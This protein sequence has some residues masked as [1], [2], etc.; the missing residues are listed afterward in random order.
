MQ[1]PENDIIAI[2]THKEITRLYKIFLEIV[3]DI[4]NENQI[5]TD[6]ISKV[7]DPELVNH[8][9]YFTQE[10]YDQVR[11]RVLDHGNDTA[12]QLLNFLDYFDFAI[13]KEKV[14]AAADQRKVFKKVIVSSPFIVE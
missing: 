3:E 14:R 9:N 12:R 6:K 5:M 1:S 13:N 11:K 8:V 10:K 7:C 2:Q 4:R